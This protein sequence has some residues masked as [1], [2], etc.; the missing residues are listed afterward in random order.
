MKK[1][2]SMVQYLS[3]L[4]EA[5][6]PHIASAKKIMFIG[7]SMLS[8]LDS[9]PVSGFVEVN[10][11]PVSSRLLDGFKKDA[12]K[13]HLFVD[14]EVYSQSPKGVLCAFAP[15][16]YIRLGLK[17]KENSVVVIGGR[18]CAEKTNIEL[19]V[20]NAGRLTHIEESIL[21]EESS[22]RFEDALSTLVDGV[23]DR[24]SPIKILL[25]APLKDISSDLPSVEYVKDSVVFKN[26]RYHLKNAGKSNVTSLA[27][28]ISM[29]LF[30]SF[31]YGFNVNKALAQFHSARDYYDALS[32]SENSSQHGGVNSEY[33]KQMESREMYLHSISAAHHETA[34]IKL[35]T[36]AV[37]QVKGAE[38]RKI[39]VYSSKLYKEAEKVASAGSEQEEF[40]EKPNLLITISMPTSGEDALVQGS[41]LINQLS[42]STNIHLRIQKNGWTESLGA[43]EFNVEGFFYEN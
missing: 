16:S 39:K 4:D 29:F 7:M 3:G 13:V 9:D 37:T 15:E 20:F 30:S 10:A 28:I 19:Y 24:Y 22:S 42:K 8:K 18:T 5:D 38:I 26:I 11:M 32:K 23:I 33:I 1:F 25:C 12:K 31:Y 43:R 27:F 34:T 2:K 35:V 21:P 6:Q 40:A 14:D 17:C 41:D 36:Y